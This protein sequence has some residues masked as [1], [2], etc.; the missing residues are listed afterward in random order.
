MDFMK[1]TLTGK[2]AGTFQPP[3]ELPP[4]SVAQK[5]DKPDDA[6][7]EEEAR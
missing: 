7:P 3:P 6:P 2:D 4:N 5:L 1:T